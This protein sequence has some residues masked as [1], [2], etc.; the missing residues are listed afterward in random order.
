[1]K[2]IHFKI[3]ATGL[4]L[5]STDALAAQKLALI[6]GNNNYSRDIGALSNPINDAIAIDKKL[7]SMGFDTIL[8]K[9]ANKRQMLDA[10]DTFQEKLEHGSTA[11]FY[12]AGHGIEAGNRSYLIP[13]E[14]T[15]PK[16]PNNY[17]DEFFDM[18]DKAMNSMLSSAAENKILIIDACR[19]NLEPLKRAVGANTRGFSRSSMAVDNQSSNAG[20]MSVL[21]STLSGSEAL[22]AS[23]FAKALLANLDKPNATW[24]ELVSDI[25]TS[26]RQNTKGTQ[27]VWSEGGT[28][29]AYFKLLPV[30]QTVKP[31]PSPQVIERIVEKP[32]ERI[33]ERE[34]V[35]VH[36]NPQA[37]EITY[38]NSIKNSNRSSDFQAYINQYPNGLFVE[39]AQAKLL[40]KPVEVAQVQ[41]RDKPTPQASQ[42]NSD[43]ELM[44]QGMWRDPKTNLVWMRCSLGQ[45]WDGKTCIGKPEWYSWQAAIDAAKSLNNNDGFGGYSDWGV[46]HIEDIAT[47]RYCSK[48]FDG[49]SRALAES[50][51]KQSVGEECK[52]GYKTPTINKVI[53]PET[54]EFEYWSSSTNYGDIKWY[55]NFKN[56]LIFSRP[57]HNKGLVRLV[58]SAQ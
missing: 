41:V 21:F 4:L 55:I 29:L 20:K 48:G 6:I 47:I 44:K 35:V 49:V 45:T 23:P 27:Q 19:N 30:A 39:L 28:E 14:A 52:K 33:V 46:P 42:S 22:D 51:D 40:P 56:G 37:V 7:K 2:I 26:V 57:I 17:S 15:I 3:L 16:N 53:F 38:W 13:V 34:R 12:Y 18:R 9:N 1:M 58:R 32:V 8:I 11:I 36:E 25:S 50:Q 5:I 31:D 10:F 24:P 54:Y 43:E